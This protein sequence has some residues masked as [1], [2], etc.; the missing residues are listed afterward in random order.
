[1]SAFDFSFLEDKGTDEN[2]LVKNKKS[3]ELRI[4]KKRGRL[5][6]FNG[7]KQVGGSREINERLRDMKVE[8]RT[9]EAGS[10]VTT[11]K[12]LGAKGMEYKRHGVK[13]TFPS[14]FSR[15]GFNSKQDFNK[16]I[17]RKK[18]LR[19]NRLVKKAAK[20]LSMGY[21]TS[22]GRVPAD[23]DFLVKSRQKF[24]N[25]NVFFRNIGGKVRPMRFGTGMR[26]PKY[27]N[28]VPF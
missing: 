20:D 16:V 9:A 6:V 26:K 14:W 25:K 11:Y 12:D 5:V 7:D 2:G 13:S 23:K 15:L 10:T 3:K 18:G 4:V 1:M 21:N 8:V 24:D 22:H 17:E 28:D 27:S 19:F